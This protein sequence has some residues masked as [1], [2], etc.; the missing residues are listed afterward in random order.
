MVAFITYSESM[1]MNTE[2]LAKYVNC[3]KSQIS[4]WQV[5]STQQMLLSGLL[6]LYHWSTKFLFFSFLVFFFFS[7]I[8]QQV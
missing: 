6:S 3:S 4:T 2:V 1:N 5:L 8:L 7:H